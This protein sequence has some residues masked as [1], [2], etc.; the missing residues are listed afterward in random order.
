MSIITPE[1]RALIESGPLAHVVTIN[2]EGRV[3]VARGEYDPEKLAVA[4]PTGDELAVMAS[5]VSLLGQRLR[6]AQYEVSDLRGNIDR[7][8]QDLEDAVFI[9][10]RE[11]RLVFTCTTRPVSR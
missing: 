2:P 6:G 10:N 7:L 11:L 8:L 1:L 3:K 9:F 4:Q 5:K